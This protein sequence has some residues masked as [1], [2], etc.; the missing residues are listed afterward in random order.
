MRRRIF[1]IGLLVLL[2]ISGLVV[3]AQSTTTT[4]AEATED[5]DIHNFEVVAELGRALP[6]K[7]IYDPNFER[8]LVVDVYGKLFLS[9]ALTFETEHVLYELG[10][11]ND[12]AFSR[13]GTLAAVAL[14]R[15]IELW[16]TETGQMVGRLTELGQPLQVVGPISFSLDD[17]FLIFEGV[18]P[19]PRSIRISENQTI[20]VPWIWHIPSA[21]G[22]NTSE[23]PQRAEAWQFFDYR[24]GMVLAPDNRLVAALP[25]RLQVL[26]V[27]TLEVLFD[28]PTDRYERDPMNVWFSAR[29]NQIYVRPVNQNSLIQVDTQ[30]GA[31]VEIPLEEPL[32]LSDLELLGSIELSEQSRVIGDTSAN[33][34]KRLFLPSDRDTIL[35]TYGAGQLTMSLIDLIIPPISEGDNILALL[36]IYNEDTQTGFFR[37]TSG[38][39]QQMLLSPDG[40]EL[41]T[42]LPA[43]ILRTNSDETIATYNLNTGMLVREF[44]PALRGIGAY[45]R[46]IRNRV[47]AFNAT[48]D[49]LVSDFQR[50]NPVTNEV[51]AEDLRYSRSFDRFFFT[52]DSQFMVTLSGGEWRVWDVDTGE[53]VRREAIVFQGSIISTSS[54]GYRYLTT[55]QQWTGSEEIFG[56]E[57]IDLN[58]NTVT[59]EEIFFENIPGHSIENVYHSPDWR[60]FLVVYALN[61]YGDYYPGNQIAMYEMGV[62]F[63]WL[64]AGDDLPAHEGR[65]YGWVDN[66][67]VFIS[68]EGFADGQ[69]AR[70]Y[71]AEYDESR[72][73]Q[74]VVEQ[75]PD[76]LDVW[77]QLWERQLYYQRPDRLHQLTQLIC[78]SEVDSVEDMTTL[79]LPTPT[80]NAVIPTPPASVAGVPYCLLLRYPNQVEEYTEVWQETI[81]GLTAEQI[82]EAEELLCEGIG[83]IPTPRP[84]FAQDVQSPYLVQTM[85]ID[86]VTG[87]RSSGSYQPVQIQRRPVEPVAREF[88]RIYKRSMG[89]AILSPDASLVAASSLPGEL[90]IYRIVIGYDTIMAHITETAIA[91]QQAQNLIYPLPSHTPMFNPIGTARPTLTPTVT[92]TPYPHPEEALEQAQ[93]GE[94]QDLCPS[95]QLSTTSNLPEGYSPIGAIIA[96]VQDN[97]LWRVSPVTGS[98]APDDT[99]P[100]CGEGIDCLFSPDGTWILAR[101]I[102]DLYVIRPDGTD[103]RL[104]AGEDDR[105]PQLIWA[106]PN[107]LEENITLYLEDERRYV[108]AVQRD[109]LGVFPDPDPIVLEATINEIPAEIVNR[110]PGG[111]WVVA[112]L[113]FPTGPDSIYQYYLY[114]LATGDAIQFAR[115]KF[116]H[117]VWHALGDRLF[118]TFDDNPRAISQWYQITMETLEARRI[119]SQLYA[120]RWS[121]N[122]RYTIVSN[123]EERTQQAFP[124][125]VWD[126][127]TGLVRRY[128]VPE[129]GARLYTGGFMWS[130]DSR[131]VALVAPLPKDEAQEGVGQHLLILD[132]ETGAMVDV[133]NGTGFPTSW[134]IPGGYES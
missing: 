50:V 33:D 85:I 121:P 117:M 11:Y 23:F 78:A 103:Y 9:N 16:D 76:Q 83:V 127:Q 17:Q 19:A 27:A 87:V 30:R 10:N 88:E 59:R 91:I 132:I 104:L 15:R 52:D 21:F 22:T 64:I 110:Q 53:V 114:N 24:N 57:I 119:P 63:R 35:R 20:N 123:P 36:F 84:Q 49:V 100:Q 65:L 120:G 54:D 3:V 39:A 37:F 47:L 107:I 89:Q 124:L 95:E 93:A 122:G 43:G 98:R 92:P 42:R 25:S 115:E 46:A 7:I 86:A 99:V 67:Q 38:S 109:I 56:R 82:A 62:G 31:L 28:I 81:E 97:V 26:D 112:R 58:N 134:I 79:L 116:V 40:N 12:I 106:G 18:Y 14:E 34:L 44:V 66:E 94:I 6:R 101:T 105:K 75:F 48:G 102:T 125:V 51:L 96:P 80:P 113:E 126:T 8:Y 32:T 129:T 1:L 74:C 130:P 68:G 13:D 71:G 108:D 133:T 41:I 61:P 55:R 4:T 60:R 2:L 118:F 131:Y 90:V 45:R 72:L 128:C 29:D 77:M 111:S 70:I 5:P 73:P 69:P